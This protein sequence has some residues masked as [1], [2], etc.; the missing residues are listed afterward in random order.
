MRVTWQSIHSPAGPRSE[1]LRHRS[2]KCRSSGGTDRTHVPS[3]ALPDSI[4]ALVTEL[5]AQSPAIRADRVEAI[6]QQIAQ[7]S[8]QPDS[9]R[10]A[11]K[12]LEH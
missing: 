9:R 6:R 2:G 1:S 12:V 4:A 7:G 11:A 8:Y 10:I 3:A 5:A